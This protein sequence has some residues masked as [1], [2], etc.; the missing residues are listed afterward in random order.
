MTIQ[1]LFSFKIFNIFFITKQSAV[2][3]CIL[4]MYS[5]DIKYFHQL[6][7]K[8]KEK[9]VNEGSTYGNGRLAKPP[10]EANKTIS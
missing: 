4:P 5:K 9:K 3:Q 1:C 2:C 8:N 7:L 10:A 6:N